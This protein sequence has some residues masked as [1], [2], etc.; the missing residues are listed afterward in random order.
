MATDAQ[1]AA[2]QAII[3]AAAQ[4]ALAS[5]NGGSIEHGNC[6]VLRATT[7]RVKRAAE[8]A[9]AQAAQASAAATREAERVKSVAREKS[10]K[11]YIAVKKASL[12]AADRKAEARAEE[13]RLAAA[14]IDHDRMFKEWQAAKSTESATPFPANLAMVSAEIKTALFGERHD[15]TGASDHAEL[16]G[17]AMDL[18]VDA[19]D[20]TAPYV[21]AKMPGERRKQHITRRPKLG[22]PPL[23]K[24]ELVE[25]ADNDV[26]V[27]AS[28]ADIAEEMLDRMKKCLAVGNHPN[29]SEA[30]AKRALHVASRLMKQYNVTQAE[31]LAHTTPEQ[32]SQLGGCSVVSIRRTDGDLTKS[33]QQQVYIAQLAFAMDTLFGVK[34]FTTKT[35]TSREPLTKGLTVT[36]HGVATST[37]AAATAFEMSHNLMVEWARSF[38][39]V[40]GRSSYCLGDCDELRRAAEQEKQDEMERAKKAEARIL[41]FRVQ[42]E[43]AQRRAEIDR[44]R[45]PALSRS[46]SPSVAPMTATVDDMAEDETDECYLARVSAP[47]APRA[48]SIITISD[49]EDDMRSVVAYSDCSGID[50]GDTQMCDADDG[51]LID[52]DNVYVQPDIEDDEHNELPTDFSKSTQIFWSDLLKSRS[53]KQSQKA[54]PRNDSPCDDA[55]GCI[56]GEGAL[57]KKNT[58]KCEV[59]DLT[60]G[61]DIDDD[62]EPSFA[63]PSQLILWRE[64]ES[65]IADDVLKKMGIKLRMGRKCKWKAFDQEARASGRIDGKKIHPKVK[66]LKP[67]VAEVDEAE[68]REDKAGEDEVMYD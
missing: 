21:A 28:T 8:D 1:A 11:D 18:V 22:A 51:V 57:A 50:D 10:L 45:G 23:Y 54:S 5:I 42:E 4:A 48:S 36:F 47:P 24:A 58:F 64:K 12:D 55:H 49:D 65:Q 32:Q 66:T 35:W 37:V 53:V 17:D 44:L 9:A 43:A 63:G 41:A 40:V 34:H 29:T 27:M 3:N 61:S 13:A 56:D 52:D 67:A 59:V 33:V 2:Q 30:E 16:E 31:V 68:D 25:S 46:P 14:R 60:G 7:E 6:E 20:I 62:P 15:T 39:G 38:K 19:F 26:R